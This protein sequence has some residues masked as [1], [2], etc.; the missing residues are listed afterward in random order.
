M[1]SNRKTTADAEL[2][3]PQANYLMAS[4]IP[5]VGRSCLRSRNAPFC[6]SGSIVLTISHH[7]RLCSQTTDNNE[8][9]D[10][11]MNNSHISLLLAVLVVAGMSPSNA[12]AESCPAI[13]KKTLAIIASRARGV[14]DGP[15]IQVSADA[16]LNV[17][18]LAADGNDIELSSVMIRYSALNITKK[19]AERIGGITPS[20]R[21]NGDILPIGRHQI[22]IQVRDDAGRNTRLRIT[23]EVSDRRIDGPCE[24][25]IVAGAN[26]TKQTAS[27]A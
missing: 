20:M 3:G 1:R 6:L 13:G 27:Y 8:Q 16:D 9:A 19:V 15:S 25:P 11:D 12:R 7:H 18:L 2:S 17:E 24:D 22:S 5:Q 26:D 10:K 21:I 4:Q 14:A 23:L